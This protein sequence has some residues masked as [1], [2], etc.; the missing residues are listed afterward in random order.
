MPSLILV[1]LII[2]S[3]KELEVQTEDQVWEFLASVEALEQ[4]KIFQRRYLRGRKKEDEMCTLGGAKG[5]DW[6]CKT[7]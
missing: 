3:Y 6:S 7:G 2:T 1:M 4:R 5:E